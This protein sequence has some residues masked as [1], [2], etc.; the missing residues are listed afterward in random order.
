L[1]TTADRPGCDVGIFC[2]LPR[3]WVGLRLCSLCCRRCCVW[4]RVCLCVCL[5][6]RL[7]PCRRGTAFSPSCSWT[8]ILYGVLLIT[9]NSLLLGGWFLPWMYCLW[10]AWIV[11]RIRPRHG[12]STGN[13]VQNPVTPPLPP[14]DGS[15]PSAR[16]RW[17]IA[18]T[19]VKD[20]VRSSSDHQQRSLAWRL[21]PTRDLLPVHGLDCP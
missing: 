8:T 16:R 7:R 21:A 19:T 18:Y 13:V 1:P 17:V 2:A 10:M 15:V 14:A 12:P 5:C 6:L 9:C 4:V 11:P 3:A 20:P